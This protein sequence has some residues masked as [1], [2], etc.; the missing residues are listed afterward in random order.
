MILYL[1][2][3]KKKIIIL[4]IV[5]V[6]LIGIIII[7]TNNNSDEKEMNKKYSEVTNKKIINDINKKINYISSKNGKLFKDGII[8]TFYFNDSFL[9]KLSDEDKAYIVLDSLVSESKIKKCFSYDKVNKRYNDLFGK[10]ISSDINISN[11]DSISYKYKSEQ[12]CIKNKNKFDLK[13]YMYMYTNKIISNDNYIKVY[14]NYGMSGDVVS[15]DKW[16]IY[17]SLDNSIYKAG[18]TLDEV[19][20]FRID[21]NNYSEFEEYIFLFKKKD[22]NYYFVRVEE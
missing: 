16:I 19:K 13:G 3:M 21:E 11:R 9:N 2:N 12:Y 8:E 10:D 6:L 17:D 1:N 4:L 5:L 20:E 14:V 18:L 7:I 22:N 15:T